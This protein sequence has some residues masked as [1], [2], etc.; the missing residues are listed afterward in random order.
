MKKVL[1]I[2][3]GGGHVRMV[4]PVAKELH[5][6][7]RADVKVL[8][9][10]T[11]APVARAAGLPV[12]Q[13]KD[14]VQPGDEAALAHGRRLAAQMKDVVD[15]D[16]TA[17]YLGLSSADLVA[18]VGA[19]EAFR[20]YEKDGRQAFLPRGTLRRILKKLEPD[21]VV[22]T[23]SPR[24]ER[25][26]IEVAREVGIPAVCI[27]DL[28]AIDEVRWIGQPGYADRVCVLNEAVRDF[29]VAAGRKPEEMV[30]TGNPAFDVLSD[31]EVAQEGAALRADEG[32]DG[33]RVLLWA[34][35]VE[36]AFHPFDGRPG[37]PT[38]PVRALQAL[39]DWTAANDDAVLCIRPRPGQQ[40]SLDA[41]GPRLRGDDGRLVL[42]GQDWPLP[43]LLHAVSTVVTLTSTVGLEGHL[44]GAR[45]VQVQGSV[46][47][48]AMPLARFGVADA[49]VP[50]AGLG[51]ALDRVTRLGRRP[52]AQSGLA[53]TGRVLSVLGA[54]L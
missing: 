17:A 38:L 52:L 27:V 16:E 28:F 45:L 2:C 35:Q 7:G 22:A 47:D 37:D 36:P 40:M 21:L 26:A 54:F 18:D 32:W 51:E 39:V 49:A 3:Y 42:T 48:E 31:P 41:L 9:L 50:V 46:F 20:R 4:L 24:A 43:P 1:F 5:E 14:F 12:V 11:A 10:T 44:A 34:E 19:Q 8:A 15:L 13:F 25:A 23:N 53:A 29:L 30:V 6:S 33:K